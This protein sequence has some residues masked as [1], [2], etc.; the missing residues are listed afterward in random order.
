MEIYQLRTFVTVAREG[1]I[2]RASELLFLS[3]PAVS[4]HIKAMEDELGL[5]LFERNGFRPEKLVSVDQE[6]VTRTL[7]AEASASDCC[8][9]TRPGRRRRRER[10][11]CSAAR[12]RKSGCSS[13]IFPDAHKTRSSEPCRPQCGRSPARSLQAAGPNPPL[14]SPVLQAERSLQARSILFPSQ[15]HGLPRGLHRSIVRA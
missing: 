7:I 3:Q 1:S 11:S 10:S 15:A 5:V 9:R 8:T 13:A 12:N 4:A 14:R 2:T 6:N